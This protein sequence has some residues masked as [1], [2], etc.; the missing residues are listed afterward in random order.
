MIPTT[1]RAEYSKLRASV[2]SQLSGY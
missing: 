2:A 1:I